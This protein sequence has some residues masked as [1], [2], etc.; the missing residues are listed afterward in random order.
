[1]PALDELEVRQFY[2]RWST[3][4]FTFC[5]LFLGEEEG[6]EEAT[7]QAFVNSLTENMDLRSEKIPVRLLR[8]ALKAVAGNSS[9]ARPGF[10]DTEEMEDTIKLLPQEER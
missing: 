9:G 8:N 10:P 5:R 7:Q 4:V 2:S 3:T 6:A 1:M